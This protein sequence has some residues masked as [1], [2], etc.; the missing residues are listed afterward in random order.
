MED[1][2]EGGAWVGYLFVGQG[3]RSC[4]AK[5]LGVCLGGGA[6]RVWMGL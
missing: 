5:E 4:G 2:G 3:V 1:G 6:G